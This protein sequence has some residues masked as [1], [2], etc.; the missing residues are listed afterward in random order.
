MIECCETPWCE[1]P[2]L[3]IERCVAQELSDLWKEGIETVCSCCGHGRDEK[4]YIRVKAECAEKME[5]L[6]YQ[7]FSMHK[8]LFHENTVAFRAKHVHEE[9]QKPYKDDRSI[10][11]IR[12]TW[13]IRGGLSEEVMKKYV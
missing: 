11:D 8:C 9:R 2:L 12:H 1:L 13:A 4:A 10:D 6:G 5:A 3:G 7:K